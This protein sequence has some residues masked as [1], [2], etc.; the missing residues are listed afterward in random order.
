MSQSRSIGDFFKTSATS[1][2]KNQNQTFPSP[3]DSR[4]ASY[5]SPHIP[6]PPLQPQSSAGQGA[7][8]ENG[9]LDKDD[10]GSI[11]AS[12]NRSFSSSQR[13]IKNGKVIVTNSDGDDT[14]SLSSMEDPD[15]L[16]RVFKS[17]PRPAMEE[18]EEEH[19]VGPARP[20]GLF[21]QSKASKNDSHSSSTAA[22]SYKFSLETLVT[23]AVDDNEVEADI[24]KIKLAFESSENSAN[25]ATQ[26]DGVKCQ[27][28]GLRQEILASAIGL[29]ENESSFQRLLD[30]VSRTDTF[31]HDLS[32]SFFEEQAHHQTPLPE[33]FPNDVV[34]DAP[35]VKILK[36]EYIP[37]Y[38]LYN[39]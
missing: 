1:S 27:R 39:F 7:G 15:D 32:C 14:D 33:P 11:P 9:A 24:A 16:L 4:S 28:T 12:Q 18:G 8:I 37:F 21:S 29:E 30:A 25:G 20:L 35:A 34:S 10:K 22:P 38:L 2:S 36:G 6:P 19:T 5:P 23:D 17:S 26:K 3:A 13:I 31:S